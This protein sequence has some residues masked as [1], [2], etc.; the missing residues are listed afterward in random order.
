MLPQRRVPRAA[1]FC[2]GHLRLASTLLA[3]AA[4]VIVFMFEMTQMAA[5]LASF[6][7]EVMVNDAKAA[8]G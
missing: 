6:D 4:N 8:V 5:V 1:V 7:T 2:F 3:F